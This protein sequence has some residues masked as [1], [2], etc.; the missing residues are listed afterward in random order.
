M[1]IT[2][3]QIWSET[4]ESISA[5]L[6]ASGVESVS[7]GADRITLAQLYAVN[8][9]L[10]ERDYKWA[11]NPRFA[12]YMINSTDWMSG[13]K[14]LTEYDFVISLLRMHVMARLI[15]AEPMK[16]S[17]P[18]LPL[19][20]AGLPLLIPPLPGG[21]PL[22]GGEILPMGPPPDQTAFLQHLRN[23]H[24][25]NIYSPIELDLDALAATGSITFPQNKTDRP[26]FALRKLLED[27]DAHF[28]TR[29]TSTDS[30][31]RWIQILNLDA[32]ISAWWGAQNISVSAMRPNRTIIS[33]LEVDWDFWQ[34]ETRCWYLTY[35]A[36]MVMD[37]PMP[38]RDMLHERIKKL[39]YQY[40]CETI[41]EPV[42]IPTE[43][44]LPSVEG[45]SG[46]TQSAL[47]S[48]IGAYASRSPTHEEIVARLLKRL[49]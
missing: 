33:L 47:T 49:S 28:R 44:V 38:Q 26:R 9:Q 42:V 16:L 2:L 48:L 4:P 6:I 46:T 41:L 45:V 36:E 30:R 7:P 19:P 37:T 27:A 35:L 1:S 32:D 23:E 22:P 17:L 5:L 10:S 21:L 25:R 24:K 31:T 3:S 29:V 20:S 40:G 18:P 34:P 15:Q 13:I 8:D 43:Y 39:V 12:T 14:K 11:T